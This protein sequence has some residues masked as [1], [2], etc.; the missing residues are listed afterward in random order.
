[1]RAISTFRTLGA[2]VRVRLLE[3]L[4]AAPDGEVCACDLAL[5][6]GRSQPTVS[7]HLRV[8]RDAGLVA[9]TRRGTT[10]WSAV[11]TDQLAALQAVLAPAGR[12]PRPARR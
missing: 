6:V 7:H 8:L 1:V 12:Q 4:M 2:A 11:R 5:P 10:I 9:A 3:L